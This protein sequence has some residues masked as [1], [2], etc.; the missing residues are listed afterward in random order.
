MPKRIDSEL[1]SVERARLRKAYGAESTEEYQMVLSLLGMIVHDFEE[2]GLINLP[3]AM[4]LLKAG[5]LDF[6]NYVR[7]DQV[8]KFEVV[9]I[10]P[11]FIRVIRKIYDEMLDSK[12]NINI[13]EKPD[14]T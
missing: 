14:P 10:T 5:F 9:E 3:H 11:R 1:S 8:A 2:Y 13:S 4:I 6:W 7:D 12:P